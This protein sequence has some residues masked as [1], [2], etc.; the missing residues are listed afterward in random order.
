MIIKGS[1]R[2]TFSYLFTFHLDQGNLY[3][4]EE[5]FAITGHPFSTYAKFSEKFIF[6]TPCAYQGVRNVNFSENFA[7]VLNG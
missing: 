4:H 6:F 3:H 7:Y 2:F 1:C 5:A